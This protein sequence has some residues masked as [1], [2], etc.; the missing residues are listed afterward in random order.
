MLRIPEPQQSKCCPAC[1]AAERI[2]T[3]AC[4]QC[5]LPL[6]QPTDLRKHLLRAEGMTELHQQLERGI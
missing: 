6:I 4:S 2:D 3:G 1:G 5:D